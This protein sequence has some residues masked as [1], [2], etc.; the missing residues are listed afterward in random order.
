MKNARMA[1]AKSLCH[2]MSFAGK[3]QS[4]KALSLPARLTSRE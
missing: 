4:P 3:S 1:Q 2:L